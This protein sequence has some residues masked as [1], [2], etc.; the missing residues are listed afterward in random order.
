MDIPKDPIM[1][2]I[3]IKAYFG[4]DHNRGCVRPKYSELSEGIKPCT[5]DAFYYV[6]EK[7][8]GLVDLTVESWILG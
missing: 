7:R 1:T 3:K 2:K 4:W 8:K 5:V 6:V